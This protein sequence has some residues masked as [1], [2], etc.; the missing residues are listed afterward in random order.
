MTAASARVGRPARSAPYRRAGDWSAAIGVESL[1]VVVML[2][3]MTPGTSTGAS[4]RALL[5]A[6][7][8]IAVSAVF[9]IV[10]RRHE[11]ALGH[12]LDY[13][14]MSALVLLPLLSRTASTDSGH[15]HGIDSPGGVVLGAVVS[16]AWLGGRIALLRRSARAESIFSALV[17]VAMGC[18]ML[19]GS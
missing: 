1:M 17:C 5:A 15:G 4:S 3:A 6:G 18:W 8:L 19:S 7:T 16:V 2:A 9:A 13:L 11:L 12:V 14:F 10:S